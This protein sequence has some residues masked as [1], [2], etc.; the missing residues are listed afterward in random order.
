PAAVS[1]AKSASMVRP[2]SSAVHLSATP[3]PAPSVRRSSDASDSSG[4]SLPVRTVTVTGEPPATLIVSVRLSRFRHE[5]PTWYRS[6]S[7]FSRYRSVT[8]GPRLVK[9]H[10]TRSLWP[11][12]TPGTPAN[13]VPATSNG[14]S[15]PTVRQCRP[16]WYHTDGTAGPRCG[17]SASSGL[18]VTER[19]PATTQEF[20]PM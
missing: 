13:V 2:G 16:I 7:S 18:P 17:S 5:S 19:E 12:T 6:P 4:P 9:P 20:E 1:S 3:Y 8:S 15:L 11:T 10:A 14:Q